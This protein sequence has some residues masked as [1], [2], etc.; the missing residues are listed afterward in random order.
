MHHRIR[1]LAAVLGAPIWEFRKVVLENSQCKSHH[2]HFLCG[3]A[4][5][6]RRVCFFFKAEDRLEKKDLAT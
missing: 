4:K 2:E 5:S 3:A 6:T 1:L